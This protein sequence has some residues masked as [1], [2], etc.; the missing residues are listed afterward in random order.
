MPA[1]SSLEQLV[2]AFMVAI[3]LAFVPRLSQ[4]PFEGIKNTVLLVGTGTLA[5]IFSPYSVPNTMLVNTLIGLGTAWVLWMVALSFL[6]E[7]T[8]EGLFGR[9][10]SY[11]GALQHLCY[12]VLFVIGTTLPWPFGFVPYLGW[13]SIILS[14]YAIWQVITEVDFDKWQSTKYD[15]YRRPHSTIGQPNVLG[16]VLVMLLPWVTT[17]SVVGMILSLTAILLTLSRAAW[18]ATVAVMV[19]SAMMGDTP[20]SLVIIA[21]FLL[22]GIYVWI[23][24]VFFNVAVELHEA[25]SQRVTELFSPQ[26]DRVTLLHVCRRII[27]KHPFGVGPENFPI[28]VIDETIR[29]DET[30]NLETQ[31]LPLVIYLRAHSDPVHVMVATGWVGT[32]I[33][34]VV[35]L[36]LTSHFFSLDYGS[37]NLMLTGSLVGFAVCVLPAFHNITMMALAALFLGMAVAR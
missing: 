33:M 2:G 36:L 6:R 22:L 31:E 37:T 27:R 20:T 35:V 18:F 15:D 32:A 16:A 5:W 14:T 9:R 12:L 17:Y 10:P 30:G 1:M 13:A 8:V 24:P 19:W 3:C 21:L 34:G 25:F 4:E 28:A 26:G 11:D 7:N 29:V 23:A